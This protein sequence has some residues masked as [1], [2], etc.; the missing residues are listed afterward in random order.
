[1]SPNDRPGPDPPEP[2]DTDVRRTGPVHT[3][4]ICARRRRVA[5]ALP[6]VLAA[7][8]LVGADPTAA[9][10]GFPD[11]GPSVAPNAAKP[12]ELLGARV[13]PGTQRRL[14]WHAN[15][16]VAGLRLDTPVLVANGKHKGPALCLTSAV[17]GDELNG[18]EI[19]RRVFHSIDPENLSGTLIGV[20][21]VN[22]AGFQRGSRYLPDR[23]DLNRYFPGNPNG[24]LASRIAHSFFEGV[25]R[26]CDRLVDLHTGSFYRTNLPQLRAD[27]TNPEV[28]AM[29]RGFGALSVLHSRGGSGTLRRAAMLAGIPSVTIEAGAPMRLQTE[30]VEQGVKAVEALMDSLGMISRFHLFS[31]PQPIFYQSTWVRANRSGILLS[32]VELGAFVESGDVLG[33]IVDPITNAREELT[34]PYDGR[35][36]GMALNQVVMPGFAAFRIGTETP[37]TDVTESA[38]D[39]DDDHESEGEGPPERFVEP[40]R[41]MDLMPEPELADP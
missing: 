24:S 4:R 17:H 35:V 20:P 10:E 40:E 33:A 36:L 15:A 13:A 9:T 16:D 3:S 14:G 26:H 11:E 7:W 32:E 8:W 31:D 34:S 25:V 2:R 5:R 27:L 37:P 18:I 12:F 23:R 41:S 1:M 39:A 21:V 29:T 28:L 19:V 22:L 6:A 30:E 38:L